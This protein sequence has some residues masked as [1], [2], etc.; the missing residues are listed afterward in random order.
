MLS[1]SVSL[2]EMRDRKFIEFVSEERKTPSFLIREEFSTLV[3]K[4]YFFEVILECGTL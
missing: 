1:L 4:E 2:R 3:Q